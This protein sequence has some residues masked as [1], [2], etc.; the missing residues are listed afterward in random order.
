M[1][2]CTPERAAAKLGVGLLSANG[3]HGAQVLAS[4]PLA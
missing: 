4:L 1:F 2:W 3:R